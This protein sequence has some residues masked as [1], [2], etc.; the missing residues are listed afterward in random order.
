MSLLKRIKIGNIII[1]NNVF[2][3]PMAGITDISFRVIAKKYGAGL[4]FTEMVSSYSIVYKNKK[5]DGIC[6]FTDNERPIGLQLFGSNP[7]IMMRAAEEIVKRFRPDIID[8]NAGCPVNKVLKSGS[9]AKLLEDP[10]KLFK[11]VKMIVEMDNIPVSVKMRLGINRKRINVV[12]NSLAVQEAGAKLITLHPRTAEDRFSNPCMWHYIALI[13]EKLSIP[14]CGNGDIK[15][16]NDAIRM[17]EETN[18]DAIMIG[19]S[20]IGKPWVIDDIISALSFYPKKYK[21]RNVDIK[22]RI[23][24]ALEHLRI[25][26]EIRGEEKGIREL[27]RIL[28]YYVRGMRNSAKLRNM[29]VRAKKYSEVKE[30]LESV[31]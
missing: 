14:V 25:S 9:G 22:D 29:L 18:C 21:N 30:I 24:I 6:K 13:K 19:R 20:L 28:P 16:H 17:I 5:T 27:R 31:I 4:L 12:E 23:S 8:I 7:D 2:V 1:N 26:C 15:D 10:K 11:I 3:A